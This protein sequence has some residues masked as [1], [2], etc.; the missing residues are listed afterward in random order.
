MASTTLPSHAAP[1]EKIDV[2][3]TNAAPSLGLHDGA[4]QRSRTNST[5][6]ISKEKSPIQDPEILLAK[7]ND[8]VEAARQRRRDMYMKYR[9][10]I[11]GALALV[12]LGWWISATVLE[13]TR[14]RW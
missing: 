13:A 2:E 5:N 12:I 6:S 9:P 7:D 8:E 4:N 3:T 14:H 10:F 11:L 1:A